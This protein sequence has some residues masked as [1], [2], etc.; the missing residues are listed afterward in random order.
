M[1]TRKDGI[2]TR[3]VKISESGVDDNMTVSQ[4]AEMLSAKLEATKDDISNQIGDEMLKL[5]R[6]IKQD[7]ESVRNSFERSVSELGK[8]C[9]KNESDIQTVSLALTRSSYRN[10][11]VVSGVP[12]MQNEDLGEYFD[13]WCQI[14]GYKSS[15]AVDSRRLSKHPMTVGKKY[16]I[17]LQFALSNQRNDF[18]K[19]YMS[20][21]SL[22]LDDIGFEL[23]DRIFINENLAL[24]D[25]IIRTKAL[26][27]K[28]HGKLESVFTRNGGVFVRKTGDTVDRSVSSH[29]D[30]KKI[31]QQI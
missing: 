26:E 31:L 12:F 7:L 28:K 18:F 17:L 14:L 15:P 25:R 16:L 5:R 20:C 24:P 30:L 9:K 8:A 11:L 2:S 13:K 19:K 29:D 1:A 27:A 21:K 10:D 23:K 6:E 4:L 22:S 3:R